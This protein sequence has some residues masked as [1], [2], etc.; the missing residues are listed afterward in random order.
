MRILL[1]EDD[2][3]KSE[4]IIS[5]I[6]ESFSYAEVET[7]K[8]FNAGLRALIR[9]NVADVVLLDMSMP[10]FNPTLDD[11][12]GGAPEHFAGRDLL[13]QMKLRGIQIPTVVVTMFDLFGDNPNKMSFDQLE[14]ELREDYSPTFYGMVYYNSGQEGW[15]SSLRGLIE[16]I[17]KS[18]K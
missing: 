6:E 10:N 17:K 5:F 14:N 15:K 2:E 12:S 1:I 8:S 16:K 13:A 18:E 9:P 7:A 3:E 11:P 4:N